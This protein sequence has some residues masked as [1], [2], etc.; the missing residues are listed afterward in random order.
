MGVV[1]YLR[2]TKAEMRHVS[3]PTRKQA[4]SF[5]VLVIGASLLVAALLG[6]FD[7]VFDYI[8]KEFLLDA[9]VSA[10]VDTELGDHDNLLSPEAVDSLSELDATIEAESVSPEVTN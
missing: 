4:T 2:E 5:T 1:D 7:F 9:P 6:A 10:P 3:W 8:L